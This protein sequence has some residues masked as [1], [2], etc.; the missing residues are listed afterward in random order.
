MTEPDTTFAAY[1]HG[2]AISERSRLDD[3]NA[4]TNR[5]FIDYLNLSAA[6][7]VADL[8]CGPGTLEAEIG[9]RYPGVR[10]TGIERSES[11]CA[12]AR[13]RTAHLSGVVICQG[14]A[15]ATGLPDDTFDVTFCRYLLEHV[16][17]AADAAREM[18]RITKPGGRIVARRALSLGPGDGAEEGQYAGWVGAGRP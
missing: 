6:D 17:S 14:D 5:S 8:G 2:T 12:T 10:L 16:A 1:I 9:E 3:L 11:Y 4:L 18:V 7:R 13:E 15:T